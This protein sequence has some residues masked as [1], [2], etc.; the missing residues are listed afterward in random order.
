ML[1]MDGLISQSEKDSADPSLLYS[2]QMRDTAFRYKYL[3]LKYLLT[4][5]NS[6]EKHIS[7]HILIYCAFSHIKYA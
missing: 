4:K 3:L 1:I 5:Q 2:Q 7:C 6:R